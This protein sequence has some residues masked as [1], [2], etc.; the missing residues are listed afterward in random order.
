MKV[1]V[2]GHHGY[3]GSIVAPA[4]ARA[5]HDVTGV[6]SFF[7]G[8]CDL[9]G[10]PE[11]TRVAALERDVRDLAPRDLEGFDAIVHL[12][13]LSNDPLGNLNADWTYA[14]NHR[15][16]VALARAAKEV[17]VS[18]FLF[19]SSCSMYGASG[20]DHVDETAPL[21]PL[22]PYAESKVRAE[23]DLHE[24]ADDGFSPVY[25]RKATA[26]GASP[27]LR[28]DLVLNNLVGWAFTTGEVRILSDG[29]P[30]R[31][32]VHVEDIAAVAV[33]LL[34]APRETV[35]DQAF[36][37]GSATENYQ[38][39]ELAEIVRQIVP[40]SS[41]E[42]GRDAGPDP[43]SYRVDF[44]KLQRALPGLELRWNA[45]R[46]AEQLLEAYRV[47]GLT[48]DEFEGPRFTRLKQLERLLAGGELDSDLRRQ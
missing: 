47:A 11:G 25:L 15:G 16:T 41:V 44:S 39:R 42:F 4:L 14:I 34:D 10:Y 30:W 21:S 31:P 3:I 43:R 20:D 24:L 22:T 19:S 48:Y 40:G 7:Y 37:V 29:T 28:I 27:R 13:A 38:V 1:L 26:Y 18:R 6:D 45:R 46:G 35:H 9:A 32:L 2:T 17:G 36:N 5:G 33:A 8:G 23:E 12:A